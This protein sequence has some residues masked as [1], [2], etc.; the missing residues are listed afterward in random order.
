[1]L[2]DSFVFSVVKVYI[3]PA[4]YERALFPH[5]CQQWSLNFFASLSAKIDDHIARLIR[6]SKKIQLEHFLCFLVI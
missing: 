6:V 3:Q 5:S 4:L 1:M 2:A